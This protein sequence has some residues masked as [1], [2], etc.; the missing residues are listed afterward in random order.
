[1][2]TSDKEADDFVNGIMKAAELDDTTDEESLKEWA[3]STR[4]VYQWIN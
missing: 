3:R 4:V 1:M 2:M